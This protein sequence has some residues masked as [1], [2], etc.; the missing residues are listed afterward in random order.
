[1]EKSTK[2][3]PNGN[4]P[5]LRDIAEEVGCTITTASY[6]LNG[7]R[8]GTRVSEQTREALLAAAKRIGYRPNRV[9]RS[10]VR[11]KSGVIAMYSSYDAL[12]AKNF[13]FAEIMGGLQVGCAKAG[14][15][16]LIHTA[17][18]G[19]DN[20]TIAD[21]LLDGRADGVIVHAASNHHLP[22]LITESGIPAVAIA[23]QVEFMP[24]VVVNDDMGGRLQARHLNERGH[25]KVLYRPAFKPFASAVIR[26][27][28]FR[29]EARQLGIQVIDGQRS[30]PGQWCGLMDAERALFTGMSRPTA[31][32][33]WEDFTAGQSIVDLEEMGLRVPEDVA[34][35]GFNG[36]TTDFGRRSRLSTIDAHWADVAEKAVE[37]LMQA[38]VGKE[39][40]QTTVLPVELV[41]GTST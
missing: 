36:F 29:E 21:S 38:V 3:R 12:N 41:D 14:V 27:Q 25:Q 31:I 19:T 35:I 22:H 26:E 39:I 30:V 37:L 32:A 6:V 23:D 18:P 17:I 9:A 33:C 7:A 28:A 24:S 2:R 40:P 1:M 13:F 4:R 16:L 34:V 10:L 15:D 5:T 8:S 20:D 11:Q